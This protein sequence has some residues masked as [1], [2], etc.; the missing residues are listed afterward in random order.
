[1]GGARETVT[2]RKVKDAYQRH[3]RRGLGSST[4]AHSPRA[5]P[6]A[7]SS[8]RAPTRGW[9]TRRA[10]PRRRARRAASLCRV[11][12]VGSCSACAASSTARCRGDSGCGGAAVR[13]GP[14]ARCRAGRLAPTLVG[15][16][17]LPVPPPRSPR[18]RPLRRAR[19][20]GRPSSCR[21][22]SGKSRLASDL[23]AEPRRFVPSRTGGDAEMAERMERHQRTPAGLAEWSRSRAGRSVVGGA[24]GACVVVDCLSLRVLQMCSRGGSRRRGRSGEAAGALARPSRTR[25]CIESNQSRAR[26]RH[27]VRPPRAYRGR[28]RSGSTSVGS[29][30]RR[31]RTSSSSAAARWR[32][33]RGVRPRAYCRQS[34]RARTFHLKTKPRRGLACSSRSPPSWLWRVSPAPAPN[35]CSSLF[36]A[37][38]HGVAGRR[39]ELPT[40]R[41]RQMGRQLRR[42]R[43]LR[44][45][46]AR[47][48]RTWCS[49]SSTSRCRRAVCDRAVR[50]IGWFGAGTQ[51]RAR[52]GDAA[53][54]RLALLS[55]RARG[56]RPASCST[57]ST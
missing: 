54:R 27:R 53:R 34:A 18:A 4:L 32:S 49:S 51:I 9:A 23:A 39:G 40:R 44:E 1:M 31:V 42:R 5:R 43:G 21:S 52:P 57:A 47:E 56:A 55:W 33:N 41:T 48:G 37:G 36:A 15:A 35:A 25:C 22:R 3:R 14:P 29:A 17:L 7:S 45:G 16:R 46:L 11:A 50:T 2:E 28:A 19:T 38:D 12:P 24:A 13:G 30:P 6:A 20:V 10:A 8:A 26:R